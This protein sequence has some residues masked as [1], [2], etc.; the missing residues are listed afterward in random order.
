MKIAVIGSGYVGLVAGACLAETGSDVICADIDEDKI[1]G[2][3]QGKIPIYEPGLEPLILSNLA[4]GRLQFTTDV[5]AGVVASDISFIAV[6][7]PADEDGSA[8]LSTLLRRG[9]GGSCFPRM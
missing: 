2:L 6:G 1:V 4:A 3:N 7:T 9:Y 5:A 8:D